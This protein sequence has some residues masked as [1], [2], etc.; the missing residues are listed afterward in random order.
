MSLV[1]LRSCRIHTTPGSMGSDMFPPQHTHLTIYS[2]RN[3]HTHT[4]VNCKVKSRLRKP[5]SLVQL[6]RG[7]EPRI[8]LIRLPPPAPT[9]TKTWCRHEVRR[10]CSQLAPGTP[11][12]ERGH[13]PCAQSPLAPSSLAEATRSSNPPWH[14]RYAAPR[15]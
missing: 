9:C 5:S 1:Y 10:P 6:R 7:E 2:S 3:L 15:V 14:T 12:A 4:P 13:Q 11:L 8:T